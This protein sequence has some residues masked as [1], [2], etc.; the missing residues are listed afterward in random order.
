MIFRFP[1]GKTRVAGTIAN[2]LSYMKGFEKGFHDVFVGGGAVLVEVAQQYPKIK[3]HAN[4]LDEN[5][6]AFWQIMANPNLGYDR[7]CKLMEI[8]PEVALFKYLRETEPANLV[9]KAYRAIFFNRTTFSGIAITHPIG[10]FGQKSKWTIDCKWNFS[11]MKERMH[12]MVQLFHG[13]LSVSNQPF[14]KYLFG[15]G[16]NAVC[17]LDPPYYKTGSGLYRVSMPKREHEV[18]SGM[19]KQR[20]NWVLSYD[21]CPEV[22][23]LYTWANREKLN[24]YYTIKGRKAKGN[25]WTYKNEYLI[26]PKPYFFS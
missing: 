3:L 16:K 7:L 11:R 8:R 14:Q 23:Q 22:E 17:Y 6:A 26:L 9:E 24:F 25:G 10:G 2:I 1:G 20:R 15:I 19:L 13:R 18:L 5:I 21:I 4:D 12:Q